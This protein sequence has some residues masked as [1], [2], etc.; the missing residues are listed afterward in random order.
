MTKP[1][2]L[3]W[4]SGKMVYLPNYTY[5]RWHQCMCEVRH[6]V[7]KGELAPPG[8]RQYLSKMLI[9]SKLYDPYLLVTGRKVW[10]S[11]GSAAKVLPEMEV[12][13]SY[14]TLSQMWG[15]WNLAMFLSRDGSLTL[16]YMTS[17]M[18]LVILCTSLPNME[19][20][21]TLMQWPEVLPWA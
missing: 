11:V 16:I 3:H 12:E 4:V 10:P 2:W 20:L 9:W 1:T 15:S 18:V 8:E 13:K 7:P 17:L 5:H 19:K 21:S 6:M 14:R